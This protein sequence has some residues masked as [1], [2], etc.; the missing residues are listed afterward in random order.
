MHRSRAVDT[1]WTSVTVR[2]DVLDDLSA[3]TVMACLV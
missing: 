1:F 2:I 3:E